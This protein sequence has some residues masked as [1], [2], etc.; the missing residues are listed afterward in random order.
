MDFLQALLLGIIQGLTEFLPVSSSGHIE[1]GKKLLGVDL[2]DGEN[3]L[4]TVVVHFATALSTIFVFRKDIG[5]LITGLFKFKWNYETKY[6]AMLVFSA[7]PI[8]IVGFTLKDE[9]EELFDG[10]MLVV[11]FMLLVTAT[12]LY[13]SGSEKTGRSRVTFA[14][15]LVIGIAQAFAVL[16]GLSRSG[17]TIAT[18]LLLGVKRESAAKFSFLM[19]L[20]PIIGAQLLEVKDIAKDEA[21][22]QSIEFM[23]LIVGFSS[24]FIVGLLACNLMINLV[25]R[26]KLTPFVVYCYIVGSIAL[27]SHFL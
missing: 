21:L 25:K 15:A 11:G 27:I 5:D 1:I 17:S 18:S 26:N 4:F 16:P 2:E 7:I 19:V 22:R 13:M 10:N 12:L 3:L 23:P 24:A 20:M 6:V 9:V 8:A 14:T